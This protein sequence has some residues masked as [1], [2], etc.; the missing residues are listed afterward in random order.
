MR[1]AFGGLEVIDV[2][3]SKAWYVGRSGAGNIE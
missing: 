3:G 2:G 1:E